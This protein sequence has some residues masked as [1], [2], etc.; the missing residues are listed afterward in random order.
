M[1]YGVVLTASCALWCSPTYASDVA[2]PKEPDATKFDLAVGAAFV[3]NY[4]SRGSTQTQNRPALQGYVEAS[5]GI[6]YGGTWASNVRFDDV[7]DV[8][9]DV[10]GG[11]RPAFGDLSLDLG[12]IQYLYGKDPAD[13]GEAFAKADYSF[14][15]QLSFGAAYYREVFA[16]T[17]WA[18][19][20]ATVSGLPL[21]LS[22]S[23]AVGTDFGTR[24]L[25]ADKVAWN[26]GVSRTFADA[27]KLDLR[28]HD[29]NYDAGLIVGSVSIDTSWSALSTHGE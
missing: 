16:D 29:S 13:Y 25:G 11:I 17:D 3:S 7:N 14:S 28:Y 9:V 10:Y 8:E 2:K 26:I 6:V 22:I 24:Q 4:I 20:S 27:I 1:K 18:E 15:K 23:G 19:L 12:Y 21:E 5:Y